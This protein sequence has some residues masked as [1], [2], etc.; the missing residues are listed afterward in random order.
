M[1]TLRLKNIILHHQ[2]QGPLEV[3]CSAASKAGEKPLLRC[4]AWKEGPVS[5][6]RC[7]SGGT[8]CWWPTRC[9]GCLDCPVSLRICTSTDLFIEAAS[10]Q[11]SLGSHPCVLPPHQRWQV[12][13]LRSKRGLRVPN[14]RRVLHTGSSL[15][16][17]GQ[18]RLTLG[19]RKWHRTPG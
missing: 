9:M 15:K 14:D 8:L 16:H 12:G 5:G 4:P 18:D 11:G 17:N 6:N 7:C 13:S 10:A 1:V 2:E 19:R 3:A